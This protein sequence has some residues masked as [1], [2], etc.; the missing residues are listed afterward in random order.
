[1]IRASIIALLMLT[2]TGCATQRGYAWGDYEQ[3]LYDHYADP[4]KSLALSSTL[5]KDIKK[6]EKINRVPPGLYAEYGYLMLEAGMPRKAAFYF[7]K[8]KALWPESSQFMDT[9]YKSAVQANSAS[10]AT[11]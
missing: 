8:E 5:E 10:G 4:T 3:K 11:Q 1:M 6:A 2:A 7:S 9:L